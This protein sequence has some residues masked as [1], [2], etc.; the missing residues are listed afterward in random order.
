MPQFAS[1]KLFPELE[2]KVYLAHAAVSPPSS[3]VHAAVARCLNAYSQRGV[4]Y[5]L[6]AIQERSE[7][8]ANAAK[9]LGAS[10]E[11]VGFVQSTTSG[12]I[13]VA[14]SIAFLPGERIV[15]FD[16]EFPANVTPWQLVA[17]DKNLSCAMLPLSPFAASEAEGLASLRAELERGGVRLV[18]V[19]AVQFQSG[20]R[21]PLEKM[22]EL[23]H[24]YGAELFVDAIQALGAVPIDVQQTGIDYL[25]AGGHKFLLGLEGAGLLYIRKERLEKLSLGLAGWTGHVDAFRFLAEGPGQLRYDRE[26]TRSASFVEPGALNV[27]GIAALGASLE[28]LLALGIGEIFA[29]VTAYLD[30]LEPQLAA[31]GCQ[32]VRAPDSARRSAILSFRLPP[33]APALSQVAQAMAAQGVV[34]ST[35]DGHLRFAP[36]FGNSP[37]EIPQV[38]QAMTHALQP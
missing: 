10:V 16:G 21:M 12:V 1:R 22:A 24:A 17:R 23:C 32:S 5:A 8:R 4:Q 6:A 31:L 30:L 34:V 27:L 13:T 2:A 37:A 36:H 18:A 3:A 9:L 19:S 35:P 25:A 11:E 7:V 20:L 14:R 26:L 38:V 28:L 15:V 33:G 29:H